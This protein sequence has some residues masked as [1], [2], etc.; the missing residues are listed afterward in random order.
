VAKR[1]G[2]EGVV[3]IAF[4]LLADGSISNPQVLYSDSRYFDSGAL[5]TLDSMRCTVPADW[6]ATGRDLRRIVLTFWFEYRPCERRPPLGLAD[7]YSVTVC[8]SAVRGATPQRAREGLEGARL[9]PE[10]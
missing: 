7:G 9:H 2:L 3:S 8:A 6:H 10:G 5:R 4:T 1:L